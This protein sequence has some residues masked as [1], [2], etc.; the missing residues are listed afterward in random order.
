MSFFSRSDF[1]KSAP[2][3][4]ASYA[5]TLQG[6]KARVV[7][8]LKPSEFTGYTNHFARYFMKR[9]AETKL[10]SEI[11]HALYPK[12]LEAITERYSLAD[13]CSYSD[14]NATAVKTMLHVIVHMLYT[15]PQIR[16][17]IGYLGS[18]QSLIR[19][20]QEIGSGEG[21]KK[22]GLFFL[23]DEKKKTVSDFILNEFKEPLE[24]GRDY[25]AMYI[26][27]FSLFDA[28]VIE[29][30]QFEG[31]HYAQLFTLLRDNEAR[32]FRPE[33]CDKPES[34]LYHEMG[35]LLDDSIAFNQSKA[36]LAY[37]HSLTKDQ[38]VRG[39]SEYASTSPLEF[40]AEAFAEYSCSLKPRKIAQDVGGAL[41]RAVKGSYGRN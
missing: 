5:F 2:A 38:I 41:S 28:V 11:D 32:G 10:M 26:N 35:H 9:V 34:V 33:G 23:P 14:L 25:L 37:Y 40:I 36:F 3:Q 12:D 4:P 22:L 17:R 1:G 15:Y 20:I 6:Q 39:L 18:V 19:L 30:S 24:G 7:L 16:G 13:C 27:V 21:K 29:G 31:L 8:N